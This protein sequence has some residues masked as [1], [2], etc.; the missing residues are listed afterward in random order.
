MSYITFGSM[1][2]SVSL[3]VMVIALMLLPV[4]YTLVTGRTISSFFWDNIFL[5][6][7]IWKFS[8]IVI[9]PKL[10]LEMPMSIVYFHGGD[11]GKIL[12][13]IFVFLNILM[14]RHLWMQRRSIGSE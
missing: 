1:T 11:T 14:S 12:G 3:M 6:F 13:L 2:I 5:Y 9:H 10:F 8:Y 4:V 7:V